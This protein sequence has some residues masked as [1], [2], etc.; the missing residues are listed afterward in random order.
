M[1]IVLNEKLVTI[2]NT[3][4]HLQRNAYKSYFLPGQEE[5]LK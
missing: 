3:E 4:S 1:Y 2:L 5:L